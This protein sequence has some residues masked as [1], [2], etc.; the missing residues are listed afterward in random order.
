MAF[1]DFPAQHWQSIRAIDD[2]RRRRAIILRLLRAT[3]DPHCRP[4]ADICVAC[5]IV[6]ALDAPPAT[7]AIV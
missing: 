5:A 7:V 1:F 6:R 4:T 3:C 2:G